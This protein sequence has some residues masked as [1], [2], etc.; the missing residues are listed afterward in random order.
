MVI[1]R[2]YRFISNLTR[3]DGSALAARLEEFGRE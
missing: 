1:R 3:R 2:Y